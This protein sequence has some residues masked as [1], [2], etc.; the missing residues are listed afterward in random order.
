MGYVRPDLE[1]VTKDTCINLVLP[2]NTEFLRAFWGQMFELGNAWNW[3]RADD[4]AERPL[5]VEVAEFWRP[6][7]HANRDANKF[8][9]CDRPDDDDA[10]YWD[11]AQAA[12][13]VGEGTVWEYLGAAADWVVTGFLAIAV[14]PGAALFYKTVI[15]RGRIA[16]QASDLGA[17]ARI[18]IDGIF[19]VEISTLTSIPG[20]NEIIEVEIDFQKFA[21]DHGL[22]GLERTIRIEKAA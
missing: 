22:S 2:D 6:Y 21:Q 8:P 16:F 7:Y 19:A 11:D 4:D 3:G 1:T 20:A 10:P 14:S 5:N 13:G 18:L 12:S 9:T 17:L 15:P